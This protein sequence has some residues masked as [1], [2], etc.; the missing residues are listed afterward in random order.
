MLYD[1][2]VVNKSQSTKM[3]HSLGSCAFDIS[4]QS[5]SKSR[6]RNVSSNIEPEQRKEDSQSQEQK[7]YQNGYHPGF[8]RPVV[9][10]RYK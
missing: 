6:H 2:I 9:V 5:D 8:A 3:S 4:S 10:I 7:E 1:S